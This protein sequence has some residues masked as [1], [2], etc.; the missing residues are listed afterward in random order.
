MVAIPQNSEY[1]PW[2]G[3]T[4]RRA[5][6]LLVLILVIAIN[7]AATLLPINGYS[8]GE[9]SDLNPTGFTPAGYAFSIW[10]LIYGALLVFAVSQLVGSEATKRR[11]DGIRGLVVAN[12][13]A[14]IS[15]I[16]AWHYRQVSLS[17][18]V[19]IVILAT[20]VAIYIRL[21]EKPATGWP[22]W[23]SMD[24][25]F[26]LYLG[27][28]T[29]ATLLN[30]AAVFYSRG[31]YPGGL[32]LD[33]WA[34]ISVAAAIA[35][36]AWVGTLTRDPIYC[37]VY[38]WASVAIAARPDGISEPVRLIAMTGAAALALVIAWIA[39]TAVARL[40]AAKI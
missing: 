36:Y 14:N 21:R 16:F 39:L 12:L 15:W 18:A 25:P 1:R 22:Q 6:P 32:A 26:S 40:T 30:L 20:L 31:Q 35:I 19:M 13:I 3:L 33:Q 5:T 38:V 7:A 34:L 27:W 9:L 8:T 10:G 17:F 4:I 29:A 37:G 11:G 2:P 24:A 28:I 23:L